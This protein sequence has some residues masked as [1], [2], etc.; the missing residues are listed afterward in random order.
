MHPSRH[1]FPASSYKYRK[2]SF[3]FNKLTEKRVQFTLRMDNV[4]FA[5]QSAPLESSALI[6]FFSR[7]CLKSDIFNSLINTELCPRI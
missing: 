5:H 6:L 1:N 4:L 2:I 7:T 3:C